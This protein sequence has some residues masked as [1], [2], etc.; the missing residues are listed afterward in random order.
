MWQICCMGVKVD[1]QTKKKSS[2]SSK[3]L[4]GDYEAVSDDLIIK[5]YV[6]DNIWKLDTDIKG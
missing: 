1:P 2:K 6:N 5:N 4:H 3:T